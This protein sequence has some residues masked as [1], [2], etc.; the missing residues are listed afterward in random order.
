ML[1]ARETLSFPLSLPLRG[2]KKRKGRMKKWNLIKRPQG[3]RVTLRWSARV[4]RRACNDAPHRGERAEKR[5]P[6]PL[7]AVNDCT[8]R[9]TRTP[10]VNLSGAA[11]TTCINKPSLPA[12]DV[13]C[14]K[15]VE[16]ASP[17]PPIRGGIFTSG[18]LGGLGVKFT[19]EFNVLTGTVPPAFS[20]TKVVSELRMEGWRE[21]GSR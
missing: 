20:A 14:Q 5:L 21:S 4:L 9:T 16:C 1:I 6:S 8:P 15:F 7:L 13:I 17:P 10:F 19:P 18:G 2:K 3:R 12:A 11:F